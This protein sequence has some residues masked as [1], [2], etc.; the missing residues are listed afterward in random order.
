[1][2]MGYGVLVDSHASQQE[3][4]T[5]TFWDGYHKREKDL[6]PWTTTRKTMPL[7]RVC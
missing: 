3:G 7:L 6:K 2:I 1:M 4:G 5:P